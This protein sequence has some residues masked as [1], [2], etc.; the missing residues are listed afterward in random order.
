MFCL[1][2]IGA[3]HEQ[4]GMMPVAEVQAVS[5]LG[6]ALHGNRAKLIKQITAM[7]IWHTEMRDKYLRE[8]AAQG[9]R[10]LDLDLL[11]WVAVLGDHVEEHATLRVAVQDLQDKPVDRPR[12]HSN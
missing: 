10:Q 5:Q 7:I 2:A 8:I 9:A 11:D 4:E 12:Q 6:R 1:G 3:H